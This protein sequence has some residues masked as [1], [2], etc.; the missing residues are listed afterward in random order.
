MLVKWED[1]GWCFRGL[2]LEDGAERIG[3]GQYNQVTR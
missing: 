1:A 2:E 3:G